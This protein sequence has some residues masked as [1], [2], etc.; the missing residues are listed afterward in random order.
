MF[1]SG[2]GHLRTIL[3]ANIATICN[4]YCAS[5]FVHTRGHTHLCALCSVQGKPTSTRLLL[6]RM[7]NIY[8]SC[9]WIYLSTHIFWIISDKLVSALCIN[10]MLWCALEWSSCNP[11]TAALQVFF[12]AGTS[13]FLTCFASL[14]A[15]LFAGQVTGMAAADIMRRTERWQVCSQ[16]RFATRFLLDGHDRFGAKMPSGKLP[17]TIPMREAS[18]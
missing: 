4:T 6:V 12:V 18:G 3:H 15:H 14:Y 8:T 11:R 13:V 2:Y 9:F 10:R 7:Y 17:L 5:R 16:S 1:P